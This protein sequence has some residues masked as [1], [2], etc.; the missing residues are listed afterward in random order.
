MSQE[1]QKMRG[2]VK[3]MPVLKR[4]TALEDQ[5]SYGKRHGFSK[6][7]MGRYRTQLKEL[8]AEVRIHREKRK[9]SLK[10]FRKLNKK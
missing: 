6:S 2:R 3:D 5:I 8:K 10:K 7:L 1:R 9:A 4:I